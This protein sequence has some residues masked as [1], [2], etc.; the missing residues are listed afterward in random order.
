MAFSKVSFVKFVRSLGDG[1]L[2]HFYNQG[3]DKRLGQMDITNNGWCHGVAV[4]WLRFKKQN[5]PSDTSFWDWL[6]SPKGASACSMQM[7]DQAVRPKLA[8]LFANKA[9][10]GGFVD[11]P[12][13]ISQLKDD[14]GNKNKVWLKQAGLGFMGKH[15]GGGSTANL[16]LNASG[17]PGGYARIGL[18]FVGGGGHAVA[19][20]KDGHNWRFMDPNAGEVLV[21][22]TAKFN[23]FFQKF[24]AM[25]Y[26]TWGLAS[27]YVEK[28]A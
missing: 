9:Y 27:H 26:P 14:Y 3:Q 12:T 16:A 8:L 28:Y 10:K 6:A 18:F 25:R 13:A 19:A 24:Y 4:H 11:K 20:V 7:A 22:S 5:G 1:E 23:D 15:E 2:I 21:K 17:T